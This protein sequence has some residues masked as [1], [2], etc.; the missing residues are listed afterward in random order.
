MANKP[1]RLKAQ[2]SFGTG[3]RPLMQRTFRA[4]LVVTPN[5]TERYR[6]IAD[7]IQFAAFGEPAPPPTP[8]DLEATASDLQRR[9]RNLGVEAVAFLLSP[10]PIRFSR[11]QLEYLSERTFE[12]ATGQNLRLYEDRW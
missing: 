6:K 5:T 11:S 8:S 9:A 2:I 7:D 1:T 12:A 4:A 3:A 10:L